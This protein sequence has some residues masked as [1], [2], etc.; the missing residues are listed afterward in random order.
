M[1]RTQI[2][3]AL[4][5]STIPCAHYCFPVGNAPKLPWCV[6]YENEDDPLFADNKRLVESPKWTVELY[7]SY[8]DET[9]EALL[10]NCLASIGSFT[11][12]ESWLAEEN[13][14]L[15]TYMIKPLKG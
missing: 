1:N 9:T 10:E 5:A 6:F 3:T 8:A 15:I 4:S 2:Y 12:T 7:E 11:K 14:L 13:C